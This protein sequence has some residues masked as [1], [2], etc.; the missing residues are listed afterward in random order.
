MA[1]LKSYDSPDSSGP[2]QARKRASTRTSWKP[3]QSG[4]PAGRKPGPSWAA[5]MRELTEKSPAELESELGGAST[6][7]GRALAELPPDVPLK[8]ILAARVL[9]A[10]MAEPSASMMNWLANSESALLIEERLSALEKAQAESKARERET[11]NE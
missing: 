7:L 4:N 9:V 2:V 6:Q 11:K 1:D 5:L 10:I 3:G 8:T